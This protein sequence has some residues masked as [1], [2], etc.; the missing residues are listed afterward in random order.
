MTNWFPDGVKWHKNKPN[1]KLKPNPPQET[2]AMKKE[3][4]DYDVKTFVASQD[5]FKIAGLSANDFCSPEAIQ[6]AEAKVE[7]MCASTMMPLY[8]RD[9]LKPTW[10]AFSLAKHAYACF[11]RKY[12]P[13][14]QEYNE[15]NV[16][17]SFDDN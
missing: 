10:L 6:M 12:F 8:A 15:N 16:N 9:S 11:Y 14:K 5:C 2:E 3:C 17:I 7:A 4:V 1:K 13:P